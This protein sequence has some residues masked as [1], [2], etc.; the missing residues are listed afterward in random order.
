MH[1]HPHKQTYGSRAH[2][3]SNPTAKAILETIER[4]KSNLAVS[5]DVTKAEDLLVII[6]AVGPYVCMIKVN[7]PFTTWKLTY[8]HL[9]FCFVF[10]DTR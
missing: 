7:Y 4:K 6:N 2:N 1:S 8:S 5:V 3:F 9:L 10:A